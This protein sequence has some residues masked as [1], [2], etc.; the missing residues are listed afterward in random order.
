MTDLRTR[1]DTRS[2]AGD[3][4]LDGRLLAQDDSVYTAVVLSLFT[5][6]R[7]DPADELPVGDHD[8]RGWWADAVPDVGGDRIGSRLWL[9]KREKQ[10]QETLNK[11]REYC[12]EALQ[13]LVEDGEASRVQVDTRWI[14]RGVMA[15]DIAIDLASGGRFAETFQQN[16]EAA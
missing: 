16:L 10:T 4:V 13:W 9:L 8:R 7:A 6:R 1:F 11:A 15:V 12:Q 14:D 5:D 3:L 2:L